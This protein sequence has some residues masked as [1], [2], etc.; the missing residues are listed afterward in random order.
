MYWSK[1]LTFKRQ[2]KSSKSDGEQKRQIKRN[3]QKACVRLFLHLPLSTCCFP[4]LFQT[5]TVRNSDIYSIN[6]QHN[7]HQY[8]RTQTS[9]TTNTAETE[10][11]V[12]LTRM[13]KYSR[14]VQ[15]KSK[16]SVSNWLHVFCQ[17][18]GLDCPNALIK[19]LLFHSFVNKY[20]QIM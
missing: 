12:S 9:S 11:A 1:L 10:A 13:L 18:T 20:I 6:C 2:R 15:H 5:Q 8:V 19:S 3:R 16:F 14:A 7:Q 4:S 17:C